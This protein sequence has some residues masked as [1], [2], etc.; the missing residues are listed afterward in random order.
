MTI[1]ALYNRLTKNGLDAEITAIYHNGH[2]IPAIRVKHDYDGLYPTTAA[3]S[4]HNTAFNAA[5]KNG[6]YA[7][8]RGHHTATYIYNR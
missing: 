8:A 4:A 7:E 3:L 1:N 2:E 6:F 5:R